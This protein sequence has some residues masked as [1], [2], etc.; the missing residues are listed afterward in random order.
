VLE[1]EDKLILGVLPLSH[2]LRGLCVHARTDL[3][4]RYWWEGIKETKILSRVCYNASA[5]FKITCYYKRAAN[6]LQSIAWWASNL[7]FRENI[8]KLTNLCELQD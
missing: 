7:K 6:G 2:V 1:Y 5:E 4:L 3:S 8:E